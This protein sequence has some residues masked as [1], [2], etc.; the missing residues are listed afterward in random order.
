MRSNVDDNAPTDKK[1]YT[2]DA[3]FLN[4]NPIEV[5]AGIGLNHVDLGWNSGCNG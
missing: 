2:E 5:E 1:S 4:E 3:C